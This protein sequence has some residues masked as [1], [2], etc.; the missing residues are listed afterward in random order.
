[1]IVPECA[2]F[3]AP[4]IRMHGAAADISGSPITAR[5]GTLDLDLTGGEFLSMVG[6]DGCGKSTL[7]RMIAGLIPL[8]SGEIH[9][10]DRRVS[11]PQTDVGIVFTE[12]NLMEWRTSLENVVLQAE[13]RGMDLRA[14]KEQARRLLVLLGL[15]GHENRKPDELTASQQVRVALC[16]ALLPFPPLLLMDDP[17]RRLDPL[18]REQLATDLQRLKLTPR[19]TSILATSQIMEAVQLSDRI[20]VMAPD[21][22]IVQLLTIDLPRPRRLDKATVPLI[23]DYSSAIRTTLQAQGILS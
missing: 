9:I 19:L 2:P 12:P 18:S 3:S 8:K 20:G 22:G 6:P 21:G 11:S 16:R 10:G 17:F 14:G 13:V 7:I 4:R 1:M 5:Q 23:M 15:E